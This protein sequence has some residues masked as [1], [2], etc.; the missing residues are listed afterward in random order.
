MQCRAT[1]ERWTLAVNNGAV[2]SAAY[3]DGAR[4]G[5]IDGAW[6]GSAG[7]V[8]RVIRYDT[9][10]DGPGLGTGRVLGDK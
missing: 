3:R 5:G 4:E 2:N 10:V 1:L 7:L 8:G 6:T 9:V